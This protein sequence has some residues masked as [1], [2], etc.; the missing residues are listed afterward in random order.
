M[1]RF[2]WL[3]LENFD[4]CYY[5][6]GIVTAVDNKPFPK[7]WSENILWQE[8]KC[9]CMR[10]LHFRRGFASRIFFVK[11]FF[12]NIKKEPFTKSCEN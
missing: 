11:N 6:L 5:Y 12:R 4:G 8:S 9:V 1:K 3:L 2:H 7:Y 10:F